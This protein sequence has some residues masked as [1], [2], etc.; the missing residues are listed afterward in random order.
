MKK[1]LLGSLVMV[2]VWSIVTSYAGDEF[3]TSEKLSIAD[4]ENYMKREGYPRVE[5][6]HQEGNKATI[7]FPD[8]GRF[9]K[10]E[11]IRFNSGKWVCAPAK[12]SVVPRLIYITK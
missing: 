4:V 11:V 3:V 2:L 10:R 5:G 7:Y 8:G 9:A 6:I 12:G 1:A